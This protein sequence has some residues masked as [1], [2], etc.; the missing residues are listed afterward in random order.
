MKKTLFFIVVIVLVGFGVYKVLSI[1]S[2]TVTT[3]QETPDQVLETNL[4]IDESLAT[5]KTYS[6]LDKYTTFKIIYPQFKNASPEFNKKIE[7][8]ITT[9]INQQKKD[10]ADNWQA[11]YD[12][13]TKGENI[14]QFPKEVDKFYFNASWK[15]VQQ[16]DKFI[17]FTLTISAFVGGA[18]GYETITA[19]NY[20]VVNKKEVT[21]AEL[22]PQDASFLKTLSDF[23]RKDL[24]AQFR[25]RLEVKTKED[26]KNFQSGVMPM[27]VD[28][29]TPTLENFNVFTF[30]DEIVTIYFNQYQVAP[31]A[32]GGS[33][34]VISRK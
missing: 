18:H 12:T 6:T 31:Y 8:F 21:L 28:G 26:E 5:E 2:K 17:S 20:D 11:R 23:S 3:N 9:G 4:V 22:F 29:T 16:N 1:S 33:S 19:F 10:A 15:P 25:K 30:T 34:V 24:T 14:P 13:Q 27:L 7:E 32:M